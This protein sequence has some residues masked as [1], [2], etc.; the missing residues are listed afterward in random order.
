MRTALATI[1]LLQAVALS[2]TSTAAAAAQ[3]VGDTVR[4]R[5]LASKWCE[6]CH[7]LDGSSGT[8]AAPSLRSIS[9]KGSKSPGFLR[10][11]LAQPHA[12]MP[13]L[14][15]SNQNIEDIVAYF[16]ELSRDKKPR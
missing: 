9:A 14:Q 8:D 2:A 1:L 5:E 4:G 16:A 12:P 13:P 11:F 15:L 3:I 7:V 6:T 10:S